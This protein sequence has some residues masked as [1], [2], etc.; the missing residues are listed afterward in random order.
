MKHLVIP[1]PFTKELTDVVSV[2]V[3]LFLETYVPTNQCILHYLYP[4]ST[5]KVFSNHKQ[6][7]T[8]T[9]AYCLSTAG[10]GICRHLWPNPDV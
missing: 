4:M 1:A 6:T 3:I 5:I 7:T 8:N 9:M 10:K 2:R